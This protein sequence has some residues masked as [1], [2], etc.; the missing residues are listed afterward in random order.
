MTRFT[1]E[2]N[3]LI[4][5]LFIKKEPN[6]EK[7]TPPNIYRTDHDAEIRMHDNRQEYAL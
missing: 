4:S 6:N 5:P 7:T 2:V 3:M 1:E